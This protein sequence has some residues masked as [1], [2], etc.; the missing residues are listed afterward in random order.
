MPAGVEALL[1]GATESLAREHQTLR[2]MIEEQLSRIEEQ[3][4]L[5]DAQISEM[6]DKSTEAAP[7]GGADESPGGGGFFWCCSGHHDDFKQPPPKF[8]EQQE[9]ELGIHFED[10]D[11]AA[12]DDGDEKGM[13]AHNDF[14]SFVPDEGQGPKHDVVRHVSM[15]GGLNEFNDRLHKK[16][17]AKEAEHD[18]CLGKFITSRPFVIF[19]AA[20]I[21]LDQG[22]TVYSANK[23]MRD[24]TS[25]SDLTWLTVLE[26]II[27]SVY[28]LEL[29][30]KLVVHRIWYFRG[31]NAIWN[32][33]DGA[34]VMYTLVNLVA[35]KSEVDLTFLRS[36]RVL[37]IGKV[38]RALRVFQALSIVEDLQTMVDSL[39]NCFPKFLWSIVLLAFILYIFALVFTQTAAA[40]VLNQDDLQSDEMAKV[41]ADLDEFFGSVEVSLFSLY[42]VISFGIGWTKLKDAIE[43][44]GVLGQVFLVFFHVFWN[45]AVANIVTTFFLSRVIKFTQPGPREKMKQ[46]LLQNAID[47]KELTDLFNGFSEGMGCTEMSA[48]DLAKCTRDPKVHEFFAIRG[49]EIRDEEVFAKLVT[50]KVEQQKVN[51]QL[52]AS[53][54]TQI[55]RC[56]ECCCNLQGHAS[57]LD[58]YSLGY[59]LKKFH[60]NRQ[61]KMDSLVQNMQKMVDKFGLNKEAGHSRG[62]PFKVAKR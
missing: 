26:I 17:K 31:P 28:T 56:A 19:L 25:I 51:E 1:K 3:R 50:D 23:I 42:K 2:A 60:A 39:I 57:T 48:N 36:L 20:I 32:V 10:A 16:T 12:D 44:T 40:Y 14:G 58:L 37:R 46:S 35:H 8:T 13:Y 33:F 47:S 52:G 27:T 22:L 54:K 18:S 9:K 55:E 59:E 29:V 53:G 6:Q 11:E 43:P 62:L 49:I 5:L 61:E 21:F 41:L 45:I 15:G 34:L 7:A 4:L 24:R 30:L 38:L